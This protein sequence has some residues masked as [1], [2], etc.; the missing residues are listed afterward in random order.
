MEG[1][2][3]DLDVDTFGEASEMPADD[4]WVKQVG[5]AVARAT[6]RQPGSSA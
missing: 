5:D 4:P 2:R 3:Y 6:G 1:L